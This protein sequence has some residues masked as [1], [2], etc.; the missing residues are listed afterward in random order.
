MI[1]L[2]Y[3]SDEGQV[4]FDING[5]YYEYKLDTGYFPELLR[6]NKHRSGKA[7]NFVKKRGREVIKNVRQIS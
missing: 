6:L 1:T 4:G 2:T 5:K 3:I 7:L